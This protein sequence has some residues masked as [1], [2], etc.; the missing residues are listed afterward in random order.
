MSSKWSVRKG[1]RTV[2][3]SSRVL[4]RSRLPTLPLLPLLTALPFLPLPSL[5]PS[6]FLSLPL[7]PIALSLSLNRR[8]FMCV[9]ARLLHGARVSRKNVVFSY[10]EVEKM[11]RTATSNEPWGASEEIKLK[12]ADATYDL[13]V[14]QDRRTRAH[15][16]HAIGDATS[17]REGERERGAVHRE[18]RRAE[19]STTHVNERC[20]RGRDVRNEGR[21]AGSACSSHAKAVTGLAAACPVAAC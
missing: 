5:S 18:G 4:P 16:K 13:Y 21:G 14:V 12:I 8:R 15:V 19:K 6:P 17:E 10:T 11:V 9:D 20:K 3:A 1:L 2:Y 7:R